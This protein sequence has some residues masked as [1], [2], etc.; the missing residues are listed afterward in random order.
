MRIPSGRGPREG[1]EFRVQG[2]DEQWLARAVVARG[3]P[4]R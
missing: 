4:W 2:D 3:V 1:V